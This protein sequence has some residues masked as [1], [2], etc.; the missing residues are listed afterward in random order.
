MLGTMK[1]QAAKAAANVMMR[2]RRGGLMAPRQASLRW[3]RQIGPSG[4]H[5]WARGAGPRERPIWRRFLGGSTRSVLLGSAPIVDIG[6]VEGDQIVGTPAASREHD[7]DLLSPD[8]FRDERHHEVFETLRRVDPVHWHVDSAGI[9]FWCL[10]KQADVQLV[11]R[12]PET[13]VSALGFTLT[14]IDPDDLQG[15]MMKQMLPGMDRP[16]HTRYRRIVNK[17]V[18]NRTLH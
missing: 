11:S 2:R 9:G 4:P 15:M 8:V 16:E 10:T 14:D 3:D 18:S 13:F 1:A 17:G 7:R 5:P 12:D 6:P